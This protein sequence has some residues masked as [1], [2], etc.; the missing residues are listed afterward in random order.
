V[1]IA[2]MPWLRIGR[3]DARLGLG[4]LL[5]SLGQAE[6]MPELVVRCRLTPDQHDLSSI[7]TPKVMVL[8]RGWWY[9]RRQYQSLEPSGL[10]CLTKSARTR[11]R[12]RAPR[13]MAT[14][15]GAIRPS[16]PPGRPSDHR[17]DGHIRNPNLAC[18]VLRVK[19]RTAGSMVGERTTW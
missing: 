9:A 18:G 1:A 15:A 12:F 4:S 7:V 13:V 8:P 10:C 11:S 19:L 16:N 14:P 17:D 6:A 2:A 3:V 5:G